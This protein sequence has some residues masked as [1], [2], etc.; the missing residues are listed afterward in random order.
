M[1][2]FGDR[3][4]TDRIEVMPA[5]APGQHLLPGDAGHLGRHATEPR[6]ACT[7][8]TTDG[9]DL[10]N[11]RGRVKRATLA[12]WP[13]A[14]TLA[15]MQSGNWM[16]AEE[17]ER[18]RREELHRELAHERFMAEHGLD[19]WTVVARAIRA[20]LP[21]PRRSRRSPAAVPHVAAR[22]R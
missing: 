9:C 8:A 13:L 14:S 6:A 10:G 1:H 19:L 22:A 15:R 4:L 18:M 17:L 7:L 5:H 20:R 12:R 3:T 21:Q 2:D 11:I 16:L